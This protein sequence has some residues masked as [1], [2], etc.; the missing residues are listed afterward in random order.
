VCGQTFVLI[1]LFATLFTIKLNNLVLAVGELCVLGLICWRRA[2]GFSSVRRG[3]IQGAAA[4]LLVLASWTAHGIV[5]SGYPLFPATIPAVDVDWSVPASICERHVE[6][7]RL[8]GR[9]HGHWNHESMSLD[10]AWLMDWLAGLGGYRFELLLPG[11]VAFAAT[12][13]V[14]LVPSHTAHRTPCSAV[15][16]VTVPVFASIAFWWVVAPQPRLAFHFTWSMALLAGTVFGLRLSKAGRARWMRW[17]LLAICIAGAALAAV[18]LGAWYTDGRERL[19]LFV[20]SGESGPFHAPPTVELELKTSSSGLEV[21]KPK[22]DARIWHSPLL[23]TPEFRE[24]IRLRRPGDLGRGFRME[25]TC[26]I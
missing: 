22:G 9:F 3:V 2:A 5:L 21:W 18:R 4:S 23:T 1:L 11:C 12:L 16:L 7:I 10:D 15:A 20:L 24:G 6:I 13:G 8:F 14:L 26:D 19:P 25:S 17:S